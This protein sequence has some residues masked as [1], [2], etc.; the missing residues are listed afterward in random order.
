VVKGT[1]RWF[2]KGLSL[3]KPFA[4]SP[5]GLSNYEIDI[6]HNVWY[7]NEKFPL[8]HELATPGIGRRILSVSKGMHPKSRP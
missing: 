8:H 1:C 3:N 5:K 2:I 7:I 4:I 6:W